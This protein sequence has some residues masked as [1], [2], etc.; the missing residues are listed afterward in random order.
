MF[1][2]VYEGREVDA[3]SHSCF[4]GPKIDRLRTMHQRGILHRDI[5]LG[6]CVV[7]PSHDTKTIY[8]IDFGFSKFYIDPH[9]KRHIPDSKEPRDFIGNYWFS[10]VRVH[11]KG[12]G[13]FA[14]SSRPAWGRVVY[15]RGLCVSLARKCALVGEFAPF[16]VKAAQSAFRPPFPIVGLLWVCA[17]DWDFSRNPC[18]VRISLG[19]LELRASM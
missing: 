14:V 4:A 15:L 18:S 2:D 11:C 12:R 3:H 1:F 13:M 19:V 17:G 10:S 9:T 7:G 8:M 6:N 5:Q 16:A